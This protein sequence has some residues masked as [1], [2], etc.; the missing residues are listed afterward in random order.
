MSNL[1]GV[2]R[3]EVN[4]LDLSVVV[5]GAQT[6][7]SGIQIKT[8]RGVRGKR[9][10]IGN[11][12]EFKRKLG[13]YVAGHKDVEMAKIVLDQGAPLEIVRALHYTDIDDISTVDGTKGTAS[14]SSAEVLATGSF[15][16][17][18]GTASAG[19]NKINA[20]LVNGVDVLG[21][22]VDWATSHAATATAVAAQITSNTSTPN[23]SAVAVGA[24]VTITAAAGSGD[25]PNGFVVS[26]TVA[27]DV[28][29]GSIVNMAGGVDAKS[30][31]LIAEEVGNGYN[32]STFTI[33]ASVSGIVGNVDITVL[34]AESDQAL[35]VQNVS[36]TPT[37]GQLADINAKLEFVKIASYTNALPIGTGTISGGAITLTSIDDD[38]YIGSSIAKNG[39]RAFD[40]STNILRIYNFNAASVAVDN[41]LFDYA[42]SRKDIVAYARTPL[43]LSETGLAAYLDRTSPYSGASVNS[44][45]ARYYLTD[46][47][48]NDPKD[49][50]VVDFA[51]SG[52]GHFAAKRSLIDRTLGPWWSVMGSDLGML[53]GI[54]KVPVNLIAAGTTNN[55]LYER[56]LNFIGFENG[57]GVAMGNRSLLKDKTKL[58]TKANIVDGAI[59]AANIIKRIATRKLGQ[60]C[61][62]IM[63][64]SLYND[65]TPFIKN[66]LVAGRYIKGAN[67]TESGENRTWY[68]IGDQFAKDDLSDLQINKKTDVNQGSY[69]A[70]FVYAPIASTEYIAI[71]IAVADSVTIENIQI[72][73]SLN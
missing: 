27:G 53:S 1:S 16:I 11:W 62:P 28:T 60:P 32:G 63:W 6:G 33:A 44:M 45:F 29:V 56:A 4:Y 12:Q 59:F 24:V 17:T 61:D 14:I 37:T 66:V 69:R 41:A 2:P 47:E 55:A 7:V 8:Q 40:G 30:V 64:R 20:V 68:W 19:V 21:T 3:T 42:A 13:G 65:V 50:S 67:L 25:S 43:G 38:D 22:A 18:G 10:L 48:I 9:Y 73:T 54:N 51:I 39:F 70:R 31:S 71:D 49:A 36:G 5:P 15:T 35:V 46:V 23:Y 58:T 57:F 34:A 26:P 72:L 52:Y